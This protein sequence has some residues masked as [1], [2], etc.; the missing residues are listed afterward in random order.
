MRHLVAEHRGKF[1]SVAGERHQAAGHIELA[2]R[3]REGVDRAGIE[4][5]HPVGLIGAVGGRDQPVDGLADQGREFR[6]RHRRRHRRRECAR[7]RARSPGSARRYG[8]ASVPP[9]SARRSRAFRD[10]HRR[11]AQARRTTAPAQPEGGDPCFP[12]AVV[13]DASNQPLGPTI[14]PE[15]VDLIP[16][17][18]MIQTKTGAQSP[19]QALFPT[20]HLNLPHPKQLDPWPSPRGDNAADTNPSIFERL[21]SKAGALERRYDAP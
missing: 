17:L 6:D 4:D 15:I 10:F 20:Q 21:R 5:G 9:R 16:F 14:R 18:R 11:K 12:R 2:G 3:Q 19:D 8:S 13:H 1:R 7:V